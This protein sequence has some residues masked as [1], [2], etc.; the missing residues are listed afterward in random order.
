MIPI[1]HVVSILCVEKVGAFSGVSQH[2]AVNPYGL[3]I[4]GERP[5]NPAKPFGLVDF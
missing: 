1:S 2:I 4:Y 3:P 5:E